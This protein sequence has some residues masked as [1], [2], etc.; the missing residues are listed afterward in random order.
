[1]GANGGFT[2]RIEG[3]QNLIDASGAQQ[4]QSIAPMLAMITAFSNRVEENG[5]T[6]DHFDFQLSSEGRMLLNGKDVTAMFMPGAPPPAAEP[7]PAPA[8]PQQ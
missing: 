1:M 5:K 4:Q 8:E 6:V 2:M 7:P 3:M